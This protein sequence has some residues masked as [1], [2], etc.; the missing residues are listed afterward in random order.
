MKQGITFTMPITIEGLDLAL[1]ES[2]EFIFKVRNIKTLPSFKTAYYSA[3]GESGD[4][5]FSDN[6]FYIPWTREETY[7]VVGGSN[8]YLDTRIRLVDSDENPETNIVELT[9]HPTLFNV[10]EEVTG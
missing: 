4:V 7:N 10:G 2:I 5:I 1:V 3:A 6:V 9:M 8:F